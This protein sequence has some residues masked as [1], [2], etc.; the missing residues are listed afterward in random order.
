MIIL[1]SEGKILYIRYLI[2]NDLLRLLMI[3]FHV[4]NLDRFQNEKVS[5]FRTVEVVLAEVVVEFFVAFVGFVIV[6]GTAVVVLAVFLA[7]VRGGSGNF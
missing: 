5:D 6:V 3:N 2:K 7:A 1:L 4:Y